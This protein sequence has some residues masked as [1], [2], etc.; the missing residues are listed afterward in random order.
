MA[1]KIMQFRYYGEDNA[2]NY[3]VGISKATL[4]SG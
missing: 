1:K 3:P 4:K 2:K